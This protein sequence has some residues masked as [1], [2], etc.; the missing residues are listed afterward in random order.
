MF[1]RPVRREGT[2]GDSPS[3]EGDAEPCRPPPKS[4]TCCAGPGETRTSTGRA[5]ERGLV[6][7]S[8]VPLTSSALSLAHKHPACH[9]SL[10][11]F[12]VT[13]GEAGNGCAI[14]QENARGQVPSTSGL[15]PGLSPVDLSPASPPSRAGATKRQAQEGPEPLSLLL[16]VL[17]S[18]TR[19]SVLPSA[20]PLS[21]TPT[22][23]GQGCCKNLPD[24]QLGT[25]RD[26]KYL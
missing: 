5:A 3:L 18:R 24:L 19:N 13:K 14:R 17:C 8:G 4:R 10:P 23:H 26:N 21:K 25:T 22:Q 16:A 2:C 9:S 7:A 15:R 20:G 6:T 1:P 12:H 11:V